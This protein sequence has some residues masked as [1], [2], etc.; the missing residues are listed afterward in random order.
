MVVSATANN[1]VWFLGT[2]NLQRGWSLRR[3][4]CRGKNVEAVGDWAGKKRSREGREGITNKKRR[5]REVFMKSFFFLLALACV[6]LVGCAIPK[7]AT[8]TATAALTDAQA[9][10]LATRLANDR[11]AVLF[12][13]QPFHDGQPANLANGHWHWKQLCAGDYEAT[14][15]LAA[16]GSTNTVRV[17]WLDPSA[18]IP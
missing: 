4:R 8:T 2:M 9:T 12:N 5:R 7:E 11:A 18:A 14:V 6:V 1:G 3:A 13:C 16:N 17:D 10:R 15:E